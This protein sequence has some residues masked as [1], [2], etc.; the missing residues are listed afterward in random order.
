MECTSEGG[1]CC[2]LAPC[3]FEDCLLD[4]YATHIQRV[5][6]VWKQSRE[7]VSWKKCEDE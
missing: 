7:K 3:K 1:T 2:R 5:E 6:E 4:G